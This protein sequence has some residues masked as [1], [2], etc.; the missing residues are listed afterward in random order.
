M[1]EPPT[2]MDV[3]QGNNNVQ[4]QSSPPLKSKITGI[5]LKRGQRVRLETPGG[6]G[7]GRAIDYL[8]NKVKCVTITAKCFK[9]RSKQESSLS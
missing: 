9:L 3:D 2:K 4:Q 1:R 7:F 5:S 8:E 6:G